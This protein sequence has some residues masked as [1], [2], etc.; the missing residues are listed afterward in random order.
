MPDEL[1][2]ARVCHITLRYSSDT[3]GLD[4]FICHVCAAPLKYGPRRRQKYCSSRCKTV[5]REERAFLRKH[6]EAYEFIPF[7]RGANSHA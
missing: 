3:R 1:V 5:A 4:P 6:P 7:T 2:A